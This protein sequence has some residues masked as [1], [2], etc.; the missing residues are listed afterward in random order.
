MAWQTYLKD[1]YEAH[2]NQL[3]DLIRIPSV[4][5]LPDHLPDVVRAAEWTAHKMTSVGIEHVEVMETGGHPVVYGDWLHAN[6]RP[7]ILI[8]GHFD[9]QPVDPIAQWHHP[10]FEPHVTEDRIYARGASDDKGGMITPILAIEAL[11]A[12]EKKVPVNVKF[13]FEGQEEIGSPQLPAFLAQHK[14]KFACDLVVSADSMQWSE[15]Q[16]MLVTALKGLVGLQINVKGPRTDLHSGLH[17]GVLQNPIEALSNIIASLR[18]TDGRIAVAG[19]FDDVVNLTPN[20]RAQI[21]AVPFD[22]HNYQAE[23][24]ISDFFGEPGYTTVERN[25]ARPTLELNGIWGGFQGEGT[26]TV[27]PSMAHA[28]ISC[29][30]VANQSPEKIFAALKAHILAHAPQGVQVEVEKLP[31]RADPFFMAADHPAHK[32]A[33]AVLNELYGKEPYYVRVGGSVPVI[34]IFA[35]VL[36][37]P[38][39]S[40]GWS[41]GDEQLHAPNE[42]FRLMHLQRGPQGYVMLLK[43]LVDY[44]P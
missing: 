34:P 3:L 44:T 4:S 40:F 30:L 13:C 32:I 18:S 25:W 28:K 23:L 41:M 36:G 21:A 33:A 14:E 37:A 12:T 26:K 10:P 5:S 6:G 11:L 38:T 1:H 15:D 35:A 22:D 8:Y 17:G 31:G 16:P 29:R 7:T 43:Q 2:L 42:F 20:D 39:V 19:F 9:V 24:A 27:I